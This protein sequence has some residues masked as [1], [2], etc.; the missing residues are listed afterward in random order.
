M[1]PF[2]FL[3]RLIG[4]SCRLSATLAFTVFALGMPPSARALDAK[5]FDFDFRPAVGQRP[6]IAIWVR[7]PDETPATE[8]ARRKQYYEDLFFG[9]PRHASAYP[10]QVRQLEPSVADFY[11]QASGGK[12]SWRRVGFVGPL[13]APVTGKSEFDVARLAL[14]AA[15]SEGRVNFKA[16]DTKHDGKITADELTIL[17][18]MNNGGGGGQANH[19][20]GNRAFKIPGQDVV[21]AGGDVVA[22]EGSAFAVFSHELFHTLGG[23]DLYGPWHGC[24]SVNEGLSLMTSVAFGIDE[25]RIIDLDAWHKMLVGW[26]EPRLVPIGTAGKAQ[27]AAQH[28]PLSSEPERKRPLLI[29]DP[30]KGGAEYFLLEYRTPYRLG[31]DRNVVTSGLVI[32]H[33]VNDHIGHAAVRSERPDCHGA[34]P[35]IPSVFARG[36]PDWK[37]GGNKAYT[38]ANGEIP[39]KWMDGKDSGVRVTVMPHKP[40]DPVIDVSWTTP[41][42]PLAAPARPASPQTIGSGRP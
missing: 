11:R 41:A 13:A 3:A 24:L 29:Y 5:S 1:R 14:A 42:L 26:I 15:A 38:S 34:F 21:F 37:Q 28:L 4:K 35:S 2:F 23:I 9:Q 10:D 36:A 20:L 25:E 8:I 30:A 18:I 22:N 17:V 19:F 39:L 40:S 7:P 12:F 16:F 27:L 33:I 6:L 31:Y 32:W